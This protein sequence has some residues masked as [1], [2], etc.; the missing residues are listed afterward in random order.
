MDNYY[1][2]LGVYLMEQESRKLTNPAADFTFEYG[3]PMKPHGWQP[4]TNAELVRMMDAFRRR[5][6]TTP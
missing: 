5:H 4:F 1:L 3:R 2:N 6:V